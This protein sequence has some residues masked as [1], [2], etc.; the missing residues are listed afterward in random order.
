MSVIGEKVS[1]AFGPFLREGAPGAVRDAI[2]IY[3]QPEEGTA[4][5][6]VR[7]RAA[8]LK[9]FAQLVS[10][11]TAVQATARNEYFA[12]QQRVVGSGAD[13]EG[14]FSF[15]PSL[16]L[17]LVKVTRK[18][19]PELAA[20]ENV[21]AIMPDQK[22]HPIEPTKVAYDELNRSEAKKK[23]TWAL[24]Y[25]GI[26]DLWETTRGKGVNVAVID[27]GVH[28]AHP[29]L[30]GRVSDFM[31]FD[32]QA[33]R[34]SASPPFDGGSHG[35]HVCGTI[36]GGDSSGV[37]IGV[38]PEAKLLVA[39]AL[40]GRATLR[41]LIAA[42][43]WAAE[44]GADIINMSLGFSAYEPHFAK[45]MRILVYNYGVL[46]VVAIGNDSHGNSSCPGNC[47]SAFAVGALARMP[48]NTYDVAPF[49]SGASLLLPGDTP[50]RV[51]KP[52]V[53]APGVQ[54]WSA[55]PPEERPNGI[56]THAYMD[57]TSMAAPHVSGVAALLMSARP[58]RPVTEIAA[59]LRDT[60]RHPGGGPARPD[61]RYGWG[62][63]RPAHALAA[64]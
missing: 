7:S 58:T 44:E 27:T 40:V 28:A 35:T 64:L 26:E 14:S 11:R 41:T 55:I 15:V 39:A 21:A 1:P 10:L 17:A 49:S 20:Q 18:L 24:D 42:I 47:A 19:L 29:D 9:R 57:G 62:I 25:L 50:D 34:I 16:G 2:V 13:A 52:D 22:I 31:L 51:D 23:R 48:G 5:K 46:P 12:A 56:R 59:A 53:V 37:A 4:P 63:I 33:R 30:D 54:I 36:A 38:A 3:R 6:R 61:N 45:I 8:K 43:T 32:P 60:A